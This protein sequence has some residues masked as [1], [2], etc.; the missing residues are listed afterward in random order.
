MFGD[1]FGTNERE[2]VINR[3]K[4]VVATKAIDFIVEE[5]LTEEQKE[6]LLVATKEVV[7]E[8]EKDEQ[9]IR[10]KKKA[11][12]TK[13]FFGAFTEDDKNKGK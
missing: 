12:Q 9:C 11:E 7:K 3:I 8:F 2:R 1:I 5:L 6:R 4:I 13:E 10:V